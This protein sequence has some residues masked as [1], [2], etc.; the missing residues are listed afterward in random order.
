[1][2]TIKLTEIL[3]NREKQ[4]RI[5]NMI[6]QGKVFVYPTDT[7]YGLGCD[8]SN[9]DAVQ[10]I[11]DIKNSNQPFSVIAV[12]KEWV[13]ENLIVKY[14]KYLEKL[15]GPYTLILKKKLSGFLREVSPS[16]SLGIRIPD[17]PLTRV[18]Q[19]SGKPFVTTSANLHGEPVV[20]SI[21]EIPEKWNVDIAIDGG[22][23][24]RKA[25]TVI[26]LIGEPRVLRK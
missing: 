22:E 23:L 12:S 18:I 16:S 19:K 7:V 5:V 26:Y 15:P 8:A 11:R 25:S 13:E 4:K 2:E 24:G 3:K 6:K 14:P 1:M 17:H 21:E 20:R 9:P 10:R